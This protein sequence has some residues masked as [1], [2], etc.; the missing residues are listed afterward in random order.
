MADTTGLWKLTIQYY[1]LEFFV[2][3]IVEI[4]PCSLKEPVLKY[5]LFILNFRICLCLVP[6]IQIWLLGLS[7]LGFTSP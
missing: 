4:V 1:H 6:L 2:S 7:K 3:N 5:L